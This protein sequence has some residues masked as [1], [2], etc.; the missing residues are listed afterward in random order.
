MPKPFP[1]HPHH[2][3]LGKSCLPLNWSLVPKML[4]IA[5]CSRTSDQTWVA[6]YNIPD[7][8]LQI[9]WTLM[10]LEFTGV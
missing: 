6:F 4:G 8:G 1:T 5:I 3:N 10:L 9:G 2:H 7:T